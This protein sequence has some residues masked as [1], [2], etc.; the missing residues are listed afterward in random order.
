M[1]VGEICKEECVF[2]GQDLARIWEEIYAS[3]HLSGKIAIFCLKIL[4]TAIF[5]P[6]FVIGFLGRLL[7][8]SR[9]FEKRTEKPPVEA[10]EK[11]SGACPVCRKPGIEFEKNILSFWK[12]GVL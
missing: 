8:L 2:I 10:E 11:L 6:A 12:K 7:G 3:K 1:K 9:F 4:L 5:L